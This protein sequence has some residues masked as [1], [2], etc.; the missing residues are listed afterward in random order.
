V[1]RCFLPPHPL[2]SVHVSPGYGFAF[3]GPIRSLP[4]RYRGFCGVP[5][6]QPPVAHTLGEADA[7][8]HVSDAFIPSRGFLRRLGGRG[9]G[10]F[11]ALGH[12][13]A[14]RASLARCGLFPIR[15]RDQS[16]SATTLGSRLN[17]VHHVMAAAIATAAAKL[18]ASLS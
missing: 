5:E 11:P 4:E 3:R 12:V 9:H 8:V 17:Q 10:E 14:L 15:R 1:P 2:T 13:V 7:G 16:C 18:V 6:R